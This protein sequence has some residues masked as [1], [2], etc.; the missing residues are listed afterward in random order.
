[1]RVEDLQSRDALLQAAKL[2]EQQVLQLQQINARLRA[3]IA[4]LEG[5]SN[6]EQ[7]ELQYLQ[8]QIHQLNKE[9]YQ[10][11]SEKRRLEERAAK[12]E[13]EA[14]KPQ[15]GHGPTKQP[16]LP[17]V[18]V[19]H[20]LP[21]D[22]RTCPKCGGTLKPIPNGDVITEEIHVV[23]VS[24]RVHKHHRIKYACEC[25]DTVKLAPLP[26][27]LIPGGRYSNDFAVHVAIKKYDDHMPL[28]RLASSM[29]REGLQ[30]TSQTLWNQIDALAEVLEP[31]YHALCSKVCESPVVHA[32]E[33]RWRLMGNG[34]GTSRWWV[35]SVV[36]DRIS[37]YRIVDSRSSKVAQ[38][39]LG[40]Y[41]GTVVVDGYSAYQSLGGEGPR[42]RGPTK[43]FC[44]AHVRR[45]F[46]HAE[47]MEPEL[48]GR[49]LDLIGTLYTIEKSLPRVTEGMSPSE[50]EA[51]LAERLETRGKRS[52]LIVD[53]I[54]RLA[55]ENKPSIPQR[56][57]MGKALAYLLKLEPGLRV[58]LDNPRVPLDNNHAER[59]LRSVV[60]GR[61]NHY[62]S[63]SRRGTQV[64]ALF[65]TLVETAKL[66]GLDP[67][68]YIRT[69]MERA[70]ENP[71]TITLPDDIP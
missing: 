52:R 61:K 48:A 14:K 31:T 24:Y 45:K 32:D 68:T 47:S 63:R 9:L 5:A 16:L 66:S 54:I 41:E 22:D 49:F 34:N 42:E 29:K 62:G 30:V 35:W 70:L 69:A 23:E 18:D 15:K 38:E 11:S 13:P 58:F 36:S 57:A 12:A 33:T 40:E 4:E 7:L 67:A 53:E 46:I 8:E 20:E 56:S 26:K 2:L 17:T 1:M 28:Q 10:A 27:R 64:A 65:Y 51:V 37:T 43:A 3:R 59:A 25:E 21:E 71:G 6:P 19:I 60:V 50:R 44:W 55:R 39:L